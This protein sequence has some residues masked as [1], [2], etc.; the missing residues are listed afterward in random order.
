MKVYTTIRTLSK[1]KRIL[2]DLGLRD[3]IDNPENIKTNL[4]D[5]LDKLLDDGMLVEIMQ[6]I[7]QD[8]TTVWE[9]VALSEIK[10]YISAFFEDIISLFLPLINRVKTKAIE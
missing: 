3:L 5:L 4:L 2:N 8:E 10:E 9:D 6:T 1:V 7:T